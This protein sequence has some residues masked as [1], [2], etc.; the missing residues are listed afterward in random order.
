MSSP[1]D[2]SPYTNE[3]LQSGYVNLPQMQQALIESRKTG[4]SLMEI[5]PEITGNP[6][7]SHILRQYKQH[8]FFNL[9]LLY[10]VNYFDPL[11][12]PIDPEQLVKL[13][14][15]LQIVELC[16]KH[17]LLPLK[18]KKAQ[19]PFVIVGMVNPSNQQ[20]LDELKQ[21]LRSKGLKVQRIGITLEDYDALSIPVYAQL[22]ENQ[23]SSPEPDPPMDQTIVDVTEV[24]EDTA[25]HMA[26]FNTTVEDLS[27]SDSQD[28]TP[29]ISLVNRILLKA[30]E[31]KASEIH[32]EPEQTMLSIKFRQDGI[33]QPSLDPLPIQAVDAVFSRLKAMAEVSESPHNIPQQGRIHKTF[34]GRKVDFLLNTLPSER[35]E[36]IILRLLDQATLSLT[37]NQLVTE[38]STQEQLKSLLQRAGGLIL[39]T[40]SESTGKSTTL[41]GLTA[42]KNQADLSIVTIE[43]PIQRSL[44]GITQIEVNPDIGRD[45]GRILQSILHQDIDVILLDE[46]PDHSFAPQLIEAV[47]SGRSVLTTLKVNSIQGAIAHLQQLGMT[48]SILAEHLAGI[49]NQRLVR[50]VCP[51]CRLIHEPDDEELTKFSISPT[52]KEEYTCYKANIL[53]PHAIEQ[54]RQKGRLCRQCNGKGYQGQIGVYEVFQVTPSLKPLIAKDVNPQQLVRVASKEGMKPLL[55]YALS[56][57]FQ[58]ETTLEEVDRVMTD[59]LNP[60]PVEPEPEA[61]SSAVSSP[62]IHLIQRLHRVE[63][64]LADL[65]REFHHLKQEVNGL[66]TPVSASPVSASPEPI[67]APPEVTKPLSLSVAEPDIDFYEQTI[68]GD[69]MYEE[70]TDPGEW[71]LLKR[72]LESDKETIAA[73]FD[74]EDEEMPHFSHHPLKSVPDPWS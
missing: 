42:Q 5:L 73:N 55:K 2:F 1:N 48:P 38:E 63:Q 29:I 45:Y 28:S 35:G 21:Q 46:I 69:E 49:I 43:N 9:K 39:V 64:L 23:A 27:L 7:P 25:P 11:T 52:Q 32:L 22:R 51:A 17:Q 26:D 44:S 61:V 16:H 67:A 47:T 71:N 58:G 59:I 65:T 8:H 60:E 14:D 18:L 41:Y 54:A 74:D 10:G 36:K 68:V 15:R 66:F 50:R 53:T 24:F 6:L 12:T 31:C 3:L 19:P 37:L 57:V 13:V 20:A 56:L 34:S 62:P 40:G 70:L 33:L 30:L 72:Q 4:R